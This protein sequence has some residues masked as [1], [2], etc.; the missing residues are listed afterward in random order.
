[1]K[2]VNTRWFSVSEEK[3]ERGGLGEIYFCKE[4]ELAGAVLNEKNH[5]QSF[6]SG[7]RERERERGEET[8]EKY[9]C[10]VEACL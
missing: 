3:R 2:K 5:K 6:T 7:L 4:D 10:I 8:R 9:M 1:M